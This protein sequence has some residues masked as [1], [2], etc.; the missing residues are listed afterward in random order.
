MDK[1][2]EVTGETGTADR[3]YLV[4]WG[5]YGKEDDTWKSH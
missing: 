3:R 5:G 1:I 4:R 2:L